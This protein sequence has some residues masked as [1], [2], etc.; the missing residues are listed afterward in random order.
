MMYPILNLIIATTMMMKIISTETTT[1]RKNTR[2]V[3]TN[4]TQQKIKYS[5]K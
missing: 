2:K 1:I 3:Q 4:N 5:C